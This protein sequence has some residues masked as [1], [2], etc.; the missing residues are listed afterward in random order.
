MARKDVDD[1]QVTTEDANICGEGVV[2]A[3][4]LNGKLP[5]IPTPS[6]GNLKRKLIGYIFFWVL[7]RYFRISSQGCTAIY[8][9]H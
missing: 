6:S 2:P 4:H 7:G 3:L 5:D 9:V 1:Q 8:I